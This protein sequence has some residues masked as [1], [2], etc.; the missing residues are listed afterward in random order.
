MLCIRFPGLIYLLVASFYLK[1]LPNF[2]T[3][4]PLGTTTLLSDFTVNSAI[5]DD[6]Y[7]QYHTV[8]IFVWLS[9][10][11]F[12]VHPDCHKWQDFFLTFSMKYELPHSSFS[13]NRNFLNLFYTWCHPHYS[14]WKVGAILNQPSTFF[15][16]TATNNF[17][18]FGR[19]QNTK[20]KLLGKSDLETEL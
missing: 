19:I 12:K 3:C 16:S 8:F 14:S 7:E 15:G 18:L 6:A 10:M 2:L 20:I 5:L 17:H 13:W 4:Q 1:R 9:R 11:P